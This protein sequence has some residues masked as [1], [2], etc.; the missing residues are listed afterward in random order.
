[1]REKKTNQK[2][3]KQHRSSSLGRWT[4]LFVFPSSLSSSYVCLC[5]IFMLYYISSKFTGDCADTRAPTNKN[6][7]NKNQFCFFLLFLFFFL[8]F[9]LIFCCIHFPSFLSR[10]LATLK[11]VHNVCPYTL[12]YFQNMEIGLHCVVLQAEI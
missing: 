6:N 3:K 4:A 1:M 7:N 10:S 11:I 5:T 8:S 12:N 9:N 2:V